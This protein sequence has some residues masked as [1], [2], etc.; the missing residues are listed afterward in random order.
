MYS[1]YKLNKQGDNIQPW[2]TPL[3]IW[4]QSVVPCPVITVASWPT[5]RFLRRQVRGSDIPI[6]LRIFHSLFWSTWSN[7]GLSQIMLW[8]SLCISFRAQL[9]MLLSG[10]AEPQRMSMFRVSSPNC[11]ITLYSQTQCASILVASFPSLYLVLL[12][13][14]VLVILQMTT[15]LVYLHLVVIFVI[16]ICSSLMT[17]DVQHFFVSILATCMWFT[18]F[19]LLKRGSFYSTLQV[20]LS[21]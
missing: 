15:V 17:T 9:Y 2:H 21:H 20:H 18:R 3:P 6:S 7:F 11:F 8:V 12:V 19:C 4:N 14:S 10:K 5:Y 13:F 1:A 16:L